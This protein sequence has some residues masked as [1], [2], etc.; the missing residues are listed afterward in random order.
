MFVQ[1]AT[2]SH[3]G[4][5]VGC[6]QAGQG[7]KLTVMIASLK[8]VLILIRTVCFLPGLAQSYCLNMAQSYCNTLI[9][10]AL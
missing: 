7:L 9:F 1:Y 5:T 10:A 6:Q 8:Y 2:L 4:A 3:V